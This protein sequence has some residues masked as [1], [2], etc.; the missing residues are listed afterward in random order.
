MKNALPDLHFSASRQSG[1]GLRQALALHCASSDTLY[2]ALLEESGMVFADAGDETLR[3][4][5]ETAAL[6]VGAFHAVQE[7]ARRLGDSVFEGLCH[8]GRERHFYISPVDERFMLLSVFGNETKLAIVRASAIRTAAIL[9]EC[10]E[11]GATPEMPAF[12]SSSN[13]NTEG[14]LVVDRDYFLPAE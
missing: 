1:F 13:P 9:R 6:A 7:V 8:E 4:Q 11:D 5:G 14:D 3:D 2:A 12:R 10:I